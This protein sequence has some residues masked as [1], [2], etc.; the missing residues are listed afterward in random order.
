MRYGVAFSLELN[1]NLRTIDPLKPKIERFNHFILS[2][3]DSYSDLRMWHY[4]KKNQSKDVPS[5][6]LPPSSIP[7]ELAVA[8]TFI[9]L[10]KRCSLSEPDYNDILSVFDSLLPL[11]KYVEGG[12]SVQSVD[13]SAQKGFE[14]SG[15]GQDAAGVQTGGERSAAIWSA[16]H[17]P[18]VKEIGRVLDKLGWKEK[19]DGGPWQ[20]DLLRGSPSSDKRILIEVKPDCGTHNV[21]TAIGQVTCYSLDMD[22]VVK[23]IA[24][25]GSKLL[26]K[27]ITNVLTS[28]NIKILDL[29]KGDLSPLLRV[30]VE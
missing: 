1:R 13:I 12:G 8:G 23:V 2:E 4:P 15:Q 27:H 19:I 28:Y 5:E 6:P 18:Y 9:F 29:D 3:P 21:I 7:K 16:K 11:Y 17:S 26:P 24:V 22:D 25:P 20:P 30:I 14:F 10:G